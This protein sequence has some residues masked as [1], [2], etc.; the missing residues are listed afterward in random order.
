MEDALFYSNDTD[1]SLV[2]IPH[3]DTFDFETA[4]VV[5][6]NRGD[7]SLVERDMEVT[8]EGGRKVASYEM[9]D[10][11]ISH[12]GDW[13]AQPVFI[14]GGEIYS[15]SIVPFS[16]FR[17]LMDNRPPTLRDVIK[18][19]E[20]Y[21][22]LVAVMDEIAGKD[23][24]SAPEIILARGG[25]DTLGERLNDT[26]NQLSQ[27]EQAFNDAVSKVTEDS[28]VIL[29]RDGKTTLGARLDEIEMGKGLNVES[30]SS[31]KTNFLKTGK[32]RFNKD[33]IVPGYLSGNGNVNHNATVSTSNFIPVVVGE[34]LHRSEYAN[35]LAFYNADHTL[36]SFLG[37]GT[38]SSGVI[39]VP[40]GARYLRVTVS[41]TWLNN[42]QLES[43]SQYTTYEPFSLWFKQPPQKI[44]DSQA[45]AP[46]SVLDSH[47]V[48]KDAGLI[49]GGAINYLTINFIDQTITI[50]AS[51][52]L[53]TNLGVTTI[54]AQTIDIKDY[55]GDTYKLCINRITK[56]FNVKLLRT[57]STDSDEYVL[58]N[59][60]Y[61]GSSVSSSNPYLAIR[62]NGVRTRNTIDEEAPTSKPYEG[63][64]IVWYGDSITNNPAR[65][66]LMSN[67]LGFSSYLNLGWSDSAFTFE[68]KLAWVNPTT[69]VFM[70]N[71]AAGGQQPDGS[72]AVQSSFCRDERI[73]YIPTDA[74]VVFIMGGT[75][76][77]F[78][79]KPIGDLTTDNTTFTG[80]LIETIKKIQL[81]VPNALIVVA[82]PII[83]LNGAGADTPKVNYG[84]LTI[85]DYVKQ[86]EEVVDYT[87]VAFIDVHNCGINLFNAKDILP[88]GVHPS[89]P[90]GT[91]LISRK[92]VGDM[93]AIAP[94]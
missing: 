56:E 49:F 43:G 47:I 66:Q 26:T 72:V 65:L 11:I 37:Y 54:P 3:E 48:N 29:A 10:E 88:D 70:G 38:Q 14:S 94:L 50:P 59:F 17:Y 87:G 27:T 55:L 57:N 64:K 92:V 4:K 69:G 25:F 60:Y 2:F 68:D 53:A 82:T 83:A 78:R 21:S 33:D 62:R 74:N 34:T 80:A 39:T 90:K 93:K 61:P 67:A 7:E 18:V 32:N 51:T 42:Y 30:I 91:E 8:T 79:N 19:D 85:L 84:G 73:A 20:L 44:I 89:T 24:I 58:L 31:D 77:L 1:A 81:R 63:Q 41:N 45:L 28:E 71:P 40:S 5:M 75:N 6:Y 16:V 13:T 15:G 86:V 12:W 76:D 35:Q 23:V 36:N 9:P 46:S 52:Y 22:Q